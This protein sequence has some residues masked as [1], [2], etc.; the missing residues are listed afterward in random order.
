[1]QLQKDTAGLWIW[2]SETFDG[3]I[4]NDELL[5]CPAR[6]RCELLCLAAFGRVE[7]SI[8]LLPDIVLLRLAREHN[9]AHLGR[10]GSMIAKAA[11]RQHGKPEGK[12]CTGDIA[13]PIFHSILR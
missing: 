3:H 9:A 2:R 4:S 11:L 13:L 5:I 8:H 6:R 12:Q 1:M 10:G 7:E